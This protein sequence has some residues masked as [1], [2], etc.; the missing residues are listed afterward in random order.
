M[1]SINSSFINDYLFFEV[2]V[3]HDQIKSEI[4]KQNAL[5]LLMKNFQHFNDRSQ[6]LILES[7]GS[8]TFDAEAARLLRGDTQFI[9][10]VNN[11]QKTTNDGIKKAAEKI[12]WNLIEGIIYK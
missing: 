12:I 1:S 3:Q 4:L 9:S 2:L 11:I 10:S 5:S 6:R 7:L 8:I